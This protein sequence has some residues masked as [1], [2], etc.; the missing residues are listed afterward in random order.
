[1][2]DY[3]RSQTIPNDTNSPT[4]HEDVPGGWT[5]TD[6]HTAPRKQSWSEWLFGWSEKKAEER[7]RFIF[8]EYQAAAHARGYLKVPGISVRDIAE[9]FES[10]PETSFSGS[11]ESDHDENVREIISSCFYLTYLVLIG[12]FHDPSEFFS[13]PGSG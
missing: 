13:M 11:L 8:K 1:M 5:N 7:R 4:S 9:F 6:D 10:L 3:T 12:P 2:Y